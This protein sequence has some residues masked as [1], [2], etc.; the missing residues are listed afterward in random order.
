MN[1]VFNIIEMLPLGMENDIESM[2][3]SVPNFKANQLSETLVLRLKRNQLRARHT[4]CRAISDV[5]QAFGF[6]SAFLFHFAVQLS[7]LRGT[8]KDAAAC[9]RDL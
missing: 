7:Y 2:L 8:K 4:F 6:I 1:R 9:D 5:N 3:L